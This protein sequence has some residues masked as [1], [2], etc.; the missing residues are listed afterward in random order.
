[1]L[2]IQLGI[3]NVEVCIK[4]KLRKPEQFCEQTGV[5]FAMQKTKLR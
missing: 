3:L 2:N 5:L 4:A 1:M